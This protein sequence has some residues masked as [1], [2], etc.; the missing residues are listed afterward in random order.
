M[1]PR[2]LFLVPADYDALCRKGVARMIQERDED[3]FFG[4]VVTVHPL[5]LVRRT[6]DLDPVHRLDEFP[7]G[8]ALRS[9]RPG[10]LLRAPFALVAAAR[11]IVR[12][13]REE[14]IDLV[15]ATDP[16][17]MGVLAW[18]VARSLDVPFC[19]SLH[20]D[21]DKAFGLTPKRGI[22]GWVRRLAS[23]LPAFVAPRAGLLLPISRYLAAT[24]ERAGASANAIRVIPHG[25]DLTPFVEPPRI[26]ARAVF[27]IPEEARVVSFVGRLSGEVYAADLAEV[28]TR[29]LRRRRD[30]V[31]VMA[32]GGPAE[33]QVR[34]RLQADPVVAASVRLV[35]FQPYERVVAL[36]RASTV[37]LCLI[38][39]FSLIEAC[40][41]GSPVVAYDVEWHREL[42][43][44]SVTG[45]VVK[46]HDV[47]AVVAAVE[48]L[49]DD[50]ARAAEMGQAARRVAFERHDLRITSKIKR[51][52]Y[53]ELL[54]GRWPA[55]APAPDRS[56]GQR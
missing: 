48:R 13:A 10:A 6:I 18:W 22:G 15:R 49:L 39:G 14:R 21:Y 4:R 56:E 52:C 3:G 8:A 30:V 33:A 43:E 36:R 28:V 32:G 34:E 37:S 25:I 51:A 1:K 12:I 20:A 27:G 26:D 38:G 50:P 9:R 47:G 41:A 19:V 45:F 23:L 7:V 46:E 24:L 17:L 44:N 55:A 35:P 53:A 31:C 42:V 11:A 16:Y 2:I 29:L 5:A 54:N 40:A